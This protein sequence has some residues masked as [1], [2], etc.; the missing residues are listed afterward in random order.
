MPRIR[1]EGATLVP[2]VLVRVARQDGPAVLGLQAGKHVPDDHGIGRIGDRIAGQDD[3]PRPYP[4]GPN[5]EVLVEVNAAP[6]RAAHGGTVDEEGQRL[7]R[8]RFTNPDP[9]AVR[10]RAVPLGEPE[11]RQGIAVDRHLLSAVDAP[12]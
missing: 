10:F 11:S 1:P 6:D 3:L 2:V 9:P 12:H 7:V 4:V 5:R 8:D